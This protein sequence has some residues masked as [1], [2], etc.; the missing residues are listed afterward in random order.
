MG[1][2][3]DLRTLT[4]SDWHVGACAESAISRSAVRE[5]LTLGDH[6]SVFP[7]RASPPF[8]RRSRPGDLAVGAVPNGAICPRLL[9]LAIAGPDGL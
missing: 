9:G 6:A 1:C 5:S 2:P 8:W 3:D 4:C 7:R